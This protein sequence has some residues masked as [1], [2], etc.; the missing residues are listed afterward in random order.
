M[1]L[2]RIT[3]FILLSGPAALV[4]GQGEPAAAAVQARHVGGPANLAP[5]AARTDGDS[6]QLVPRAVHPAFRGKVFEKL[7]PKEAARITGSNKKCGFFCRIF[8][9]N[10]DPV[11]NDGDVPQLVPRARKALS[12]QNNRVG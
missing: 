9:R 2:T 10:E 3:A 5:L 7:P 4:S 1:Q 11:Q 12:R 8:G 6:A